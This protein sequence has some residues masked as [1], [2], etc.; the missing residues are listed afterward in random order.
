[1][2]VPTP[3]TRTIRNAKMKP[4]LAS[5]SSRK[6]IIS[7]LRINFFT[8]L[9]AAWL[10]HPSQLEHQSSSTKTTT[11]LPSSTTMA[12]TKPTLISDNQSRDNINLCNM[13]GKKRKATKA[14]VDLP[15]RP[16]KYVPYENASMAS[17]SSATSKTAPPDPIHYL[18]PKPPSQSPKETE[19]KTVIIS[20]SDKAEKTAD[21]DSS[22]TASST[23]QPPSGAASS[24]RPKESRD[25]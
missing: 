7:S 3:T 1:M 22:M 10:L 4:P 23:V 20:D 18:I 19:I 12:R 14:A 8:I 2:T 11:S 15:G 25:G 24:D 6:H 9:R 17:S 5:T 21:R 16:M 13:Y